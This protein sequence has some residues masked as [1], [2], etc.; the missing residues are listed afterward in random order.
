L[1]RGRA[2]IG[3]TTTKERDSLPDHAAPVLQAAALVLSYP[4]EE[5]LANLPVIEA[6]LPTTAAAHFAPVIAH[7]RGHALIDAQAWHVQEFDLSR[8]HS[9]H[10]SYWTAGDTRRRGEVLA[11]FKAAYRASGLIADTGGELPDYLPM[12]LEFAVADPARGLNMLAEY[13]TALDALHRALV[14]DELPHAGVVVAVSARLPKDLLGTDLLA[15]ELP[16]KDLLAKER[17]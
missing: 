6:A 17:S 7:L 1:T 3:R 2:T 16:P 8:R 12:V 4:T 14:K 10:L 15:K 13:R 5:L 11:E 9:L